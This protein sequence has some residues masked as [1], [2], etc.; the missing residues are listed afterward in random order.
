MAG[1]FFCCILS[2]RGMS[3]FFM[4]LFVLVGGFG[5]LPYA[6]TFNNKNRAGGSGIILWCLLRCIVRI[7]G[8]GGEVPYLC[9]RDSDT[10][11]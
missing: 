5:R 7:F 2:Y 4:L 6:F 9:N 10:A 11:S 3:L 8:N 1:R